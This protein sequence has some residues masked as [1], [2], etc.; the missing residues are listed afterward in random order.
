MFIRCRKQER[1]PGGNTGG[2]FLGSGV[3]RQVRFSY[4]FF[5]GRAIYLDDAYR[6]MS[7]SPSGRNSP[8]I[9]GGLFVALNVTLGVRLPIPTRTQSL[10]RAAGVFL[11][12]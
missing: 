2:R 4:S 12:S 3:P 10:P 6:N 8:A 9:S 11:P 5:Q 7:F 1:P